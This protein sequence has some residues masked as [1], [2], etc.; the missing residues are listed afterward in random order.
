MNI[1]WEEK[2]ST[3]QKKNCLSKIEPELRSIINKTESDSIKNGWRD[4][5]GVRKWI[6]SC[7][8][9]GT[10]ILCPTKRQS[11][12]L[13]KRGA[14]C[15]KCFGKSKTKTIDGPLVKTCPTCKKTITI[16]D[17]TIKNRRSAYLRSIRENRECKNCR[18]TGIK[19]PNHNSKFSD[20]ENIERRK[21]WLK[22]LTNSG[23]FFNHSGCY[24]LDK[25]SVDR[26][27]NI[28]HTKNGGE[29]EILGYSLDGYD[30]INNVV[31]EYDEPHHY[32]KFGNLREKDLIRMN[33][34]I[35][36]LNCKF[37]RYNE[38]TNK[39]KQYN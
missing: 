38:K 29:I 24:Y 15:R 30:K 18:S 32:N 23:V 8:E 7:P 9:C 33:H 4:I 11:V 22:R 5:G 3:E 36:H 2:N 1:I 28:Q 34:I 25:L 13:T 39:L 21:S 10:E 20:E 16:N 37:Y 6:R 35:K 17:A 19:N 31:V 12:R 27:W 14:K 26:G